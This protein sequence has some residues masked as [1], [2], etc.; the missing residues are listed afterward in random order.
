MSAGH[1][2]NLLNEIKIFKKKSSLAPSLP[3]KQC[4]LD[5]PGPSKN[6]F[7]SA[8]Q[9]FNIKKNLRK[10]PVRE[11]KAKESK[12]IAKNAGPVAGNV[13]AD[14]ILNRRNMLR[15]THKRFEKKERNENSI[16]GMNSDQSSP[17]KNPFLKVQLKKVVRSTSNAE[18]AWV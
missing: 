1:R 17:Q 10:T 6:H 13:F 4:S 8:I 15:K 16:T 18:N 11:K 9:N 2:L 5:S 3:T 14:A 12:R 7:L